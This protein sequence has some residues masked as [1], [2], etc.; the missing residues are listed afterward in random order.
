MMAE[1]ACIAVFS[2]TKSARQA[3]I[4]DRDVVGPVTV[5]KPAPNDPRM[6]AIYSRIFE[7]W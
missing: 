4:Q 6:D 5:A 1:I 2:E 7:E 3:G